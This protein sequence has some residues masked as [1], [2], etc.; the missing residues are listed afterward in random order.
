MLNKST[1]KLH[2]THYLLLFRSKPH[3]S[4]T[5]NWRRSHNCIR[6]MR[7][8]SCGTSCVSTCHTNPWFL[9]L[10]SSLYALIFLLEHMFVIC[11]ITCL[12]NDKNVLGNSWRKIC[13][14][15]N[16][17]LLVYSCRVYVFLGSLETAA[18]YWGS[19]LGL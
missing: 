6:T 15:T 4:L 17:I 12:Q 16:F 9:H 7:L 8:R 14:Q 2:G 1:W 5:L 19:Y 18:F 11:N 10:F 13:F 3:T